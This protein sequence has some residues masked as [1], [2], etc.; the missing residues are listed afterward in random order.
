[1]CIRECK[2]DP[3]RNCTSLETQAECIYVLLALFVAVARE[4]QKWE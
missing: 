2:I 4:K 3:T 1:M